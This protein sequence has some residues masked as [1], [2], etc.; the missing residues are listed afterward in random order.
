MSVMSRQ[1]FHDQYGPGHPLIEAHC[2][3]R[4]TGQDIITA[5][6]DYFKPARVLEIGINVGETARA[7][8]SKAPYVREYIGLDR[9]DMWYKKSPTDHP[10]QLVNDGRLVILTPEGGS[11]GIKPGDIE[12]VDFV[13]VDGDHTR[14]ACEFDTRLA[15]TLLK[16]GGVIVWHD[17]N[18]PRDPGVKDFI[19]AINEAERRG[20]ICHV[21]KTWIAFEV[22]PGEAVVEAKPAA[23]PIGDSSDL[24][25]ARKPRKNAKKQAD[26]V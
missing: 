12:P 16:P 14:H 13:F 6:C 22:T 20:R 19:H 21:E 25:P 3:S 26:I 11:N 1:Q 24:P 17:Y 7:I 23:Q 2:D 15:Y 4:H 10:G 9:P 5:L 8:L 18:S